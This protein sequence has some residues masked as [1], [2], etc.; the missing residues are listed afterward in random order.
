MSNSHY[1]TSSAPGTSS[2]LNPKLQQECNNFQSLWGILRFLQQP[3]LTTERTSSASPLKCEQGLL[4]SFSLS[5]QPLLNTLFC[6][7]SSLIYNL[8]RHGPLGFLLQSQLPAPVLGLI[9]SLA[10]VNCDGKMDINEFSVACKLITMKLR[11]FELP[12]NLPPSLRMVIATGSNAATPIMSPSGSLSGIASSPTVGSLPQSGYSTPPVKQEP[13]PWV[14]QP[15]ERQR[16]QEQFK[17]LNPVAGFVTGDQVKG[18]MMQS[19]L[20]PATLG[21]IWN[22]SDV[23]CDGKMDI[24]EFSVACK[25]IT[26]KLLGFEVPA[27]LPPILK[28]LLTPAGSANSTPILLSP[29]S[30][31]P[32]FED[33]RKE[34]YDKGQAELD[35]RRKVLQDM[36]NREREE[37]ERKERE[38]H[39]K[40]EKIRLEQER[41]KQEELEMKLAMQR[42]ME[43]RKR[44]EM[45]KAEEM[46]E[47]ARKELERQRMQEMQEAKRSD[48]LQRRIKE[49]ESL[50]KLKSEN[51]NIGLELQS[52]TE[53]VRELGLKITETRVGVSG[54]KSEIDGMRAKRDGYIAEVASLKARL[55]DQNSRVLAAEKEKA[56]LDKLL[57]EREVRGI[58]LKQLREKLVTLKE[59]LS[60]KK[61]DSEMANEEL[62]ELKTTLST[63]IETCKTVYEDYKDKRSKII[64]MRKKHHQEF[65]YNAAWTT[66]SAPDIPL[67]QPVVYYRALYD[68]ESRNSDELSFMAGDIIQKN[69][70]IIPDPGWL[71][72]SL[73]GRVGWFPEAFVQEYDPDLELAPAEVEV[74]VEV[75]VAPAV[76]EE[77]V[78]AD[79]DSDNYY[80]ALY[81]YESTEPGD[82]AFQ[83]GEKILV[84]QSEGE[85]WT[86]SIGPE[87]VGIFPGNYVSRDDKHSEEVPEAPIQE[88]IPDSGVDSAIMNEQ[89]KNEL[90]PFEEAEIKREMSEI[91]RQTVI[92]KS[93]KPTKTGGK[94]YEIATVLANYQPSASGTGQLTLTRGQLV[95]VRKKSGSGWWE[96]ELQAKGKKREIG[97]FPGS[98]VK[99]LGPGGSSSRGGSSRTTPVPFDDDIRM[100]EDAAPVFYGN[101][102]DTAERSASAAGGVGEQVIALY[103]YSAQNNDEL[104]FTKDDDQQLVSFR[105]IMWSPSI[106]KNNDV[107]LCLSSLCVQSENIIQDLEQDFQ[108]FETF[109]PPDAHEATYP[110]QPRFLEPITEEGTQRQDAIKELVATEESYLKDMNVVKE[111]FIIPLLN[112]GMLTKEELEA[113]FVNWDDLIDCNNKL[114]MAFKVRWRSFGRIQVIGDI[115]I[116]QLPSMQIYI[117]FCSTNQKA[118]AILQSKCTSMPAFTKYL[119]NL[120]TNPKTQNLPLS[121]YLLKPIQRI[122]KYPLLIQKILQATSTN[123]PDRRHLEEALARAEE[124]CSQVNEGVRETENSDRL[125]WLQQSLIFDAQEER[126]VFNS[127]TNSVGP[128]KFLHYG[129]LKKVKSGKELFGFLFNDFLL[130]TLPTK[131]ISHIN[132]TEQ[133]HSLKFRIYR[134]PIFLNE[135][136][137]NELEDTELMIDGMLL[138]TS[139]SSEKILWIKKLQQGKKSFE[140]V[141]KQLRHNQRSRNAMAVGRL[142]V[143]VV[144]GLNLRST[145][146]KSDPY[147]EV[148]L[149][150]EVKRTRVLRETL[151]PKWNDSMQ[152]SV[153]DLVGDIVCITVYDKDLF[154]PNQFMGRTE[155]PI[156]AIQ[157]EMKTRKTPWTRKFPLH[158][159]ETGFVVIKFH[160]QIFNE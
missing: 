71:A 116:Q 52:L 136:A 106:N 36:Q 144:E 11:G 122:T 49:Q 125:E 85:W 139:T 156:A 48:L 140:K 47:N 102:G 74:E 37:R 154:S 109:Q 5:P 87:R 103:H 25:L 40:R 108:N 86:G 128:R 63:L 160:L 100:P 107:S 89:S 152:F 72:G 92:L 95:T 153:R 111:C 83:V 78:E 133:N 68:F 121:S 134:K 96:G 10:D 147:C 69:Y 151:N 105:L 110:E 12:P 15:Q 119:Q 26:M 1:I 50:L 8:R 142:L 58:N 22:L 14:I 73:E 99:I 94:K 57:V 46:K 60:K 56:R 84:S 143:V 29:T 104:T 80:I 93:P 130:L 44:E 19:Q 62:N 13:D 88:G 127:L 132:F 34:N 23:N 45:R 2:S 75:E 70:D 101:D 97:W 137:I 27:T 7:R 30:G 81:P 77:V 120:N 61:T 113:V 91:T 32:S 16:H 131:P 157:E 146:G 59:E 90:E 141:E 53:K 9:W 155:I 117:R 124:L 76:V 114:L 115:L 66:T 6:I 148:S 20:P 3:G 98:Y 33:K 31:G 18:F 79:V 126:I 35:R 54:V 28:A 39:E 17:S 158:E 38:E 51:A 24:N 123:H 21:L 4:G 67:E 112:S 149:G 150:S 55:K 42:E 159:V 82:L 145:N 65:D 129:A 138:S 43:E 118:M 64:S 135:I 41:K